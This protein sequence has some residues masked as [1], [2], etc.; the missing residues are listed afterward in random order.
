MGFTPPPCGS[1][2]GN[3]S[4]FQFRN[5]LLML[6]LLMIVGT[7]SA[8]A[9]WR[10]QGQEANN[11]DGSWGN[12][13]NMTQ[14]GSSD[15]WYYKVSNVSRTIEFKIN[16][17]SW[18]NE[19]QKYYEA[20]TDDQNRGNI[21]LVCGHDNDS[22]HRF[23]YEPST[24]FGSDIARDLYVFVKGNAGSP[25]QSDKVWAIAVRPGS[26]TINKQYSLR[27]DLWLDSGWAGT[28]DYNRNPVFVNMTNDVAAQVSYLIP[29]PSGD[30]AMKS[31]FT[32]V[33][34][35]SEKT[36]DHYE[37]ESSNL[38][39]NSADKKYRLTIPANG[40]SYPTVKRIVLD[41]YPTN[42][43]VRARL[44]DYIVKRTGWH[45]YVDDK[46]M[47]AMDNNGSFTF[48]NMASGEH[49]MYIA[50]YSHNSINSSTYDPYND[51]GGKV[52]AQQWFGGLFIDVNP[53]HSN[54]IFENKTTY[55]NSG[56]D[57]F[58]PQ[59]Y[60]IAGQTNARGRFTISGTKDV[61][62]TFD[63]GVI[64]INA[65][66][67]GAAPE[68][69]P[70]ITYTGNEFMFLSK[71]Q[72]HTD[73]N[74][75]NFT[76]DGAHIFVYFWNSETNANA[77]SDEAFM[78]DSGDNVLGA[79][80]PAGTWTNC[81]V[82][83]KNSNDSGKNWN[84]VWNESHDQTL[85]AGK[86]YLRTGETD[87][88]AVYTP[89]FYLTGS[90]VLCGADWGYTGNGTVN[91]GTVTRENIPAGTY[92][93]KLNPTKNYNGWEHQINYTHVA[94]TGSNVTL[95]SPSDN[96][97]QFTLSEASDVTIAYDGNGV[98]VNAT[99]SAP[100]PLSG[101]Y[102][103]FGAGGTNWVTNW[104]RNVEANKMTIVD[105]VATKTFYNVSGQGLEFKI[106]KGETEYNNSLLL[107]EVGENNSHLIKKVWKNGTN[108]DFSIS[109]INI[110]HKADV[111]V[112]FDGE[113]IWLTAVPHPETVAGSDWYI[114]GSGNVGTEHNLEWGKDTQKGRGNE[115]KM[116]VQDG[117]A[118][119]TYYNVP[120]NSISYKVFRGSDNYEI[121]D[122]YYDASASS[123]IICTDQ[124]GNDNINVSLNNQN[125]CIHWDGTKIWTTEADPLPPTPAIH[126]DGTEY[127]FWSTHA[128][129]AD[130]GTIV[131][132]QDRT[133][134]LRFKN[135]TTNAISKTQHAA[136]LV[137]GTEND[138]SPWGVLAAKVPAGDWHQVQVL[139][140]NAGDGWNGSS[141]ISNEWSW[142][143][144]EDG[145]NYLPQ[146]DWGGSR[147][148][149]YDLT[150]KASFFLSGTN[151]L[152]GASDWTWNGNGTKYVA[153]VTKTLNPATYKFK[154]TRDRTIYRSRGDYNSL[155]WVEE[156]NMDHFD[157]EHSN[158]TCT[159]PENKQIQFVLS[160][161]ADVTIAWENYD[162]ITVNQVPYYNVTFD[163]DGG[164]AMDAQELRSGENA[165]NPGTPSRGSG[166]TFN[167]WKLSGESS[168]YDFSTPVTSDIELVA[169]WTAPT[170]YTVT[171]DSN[172]GS[173][174][175]AQEVV[176]NETATEPAEP[177]RDNY[178]FGGWKLGNELYN[179]STP[180]TGNITLVADWSYTPAHISSV[181]I[182]ESSIYTWAG[183]A[184]TY[185]LIPTLV[186][187]DIASVTI[188]WSSSNNNVATV[189]NGVITPQGPGTA[190]I[191]CTATDYYDGSQTATCAV[192][193]APCAKELAGAPSYN[194]TITGYN[195]YEDGDATLTGMWN[196]NNE[197]GVMTQNTRLVRI[198]FRDLASEY[199][200]EDA[201]GKVA[202]RAGISD[203]SDKWMYYSAGTGL[204]YLQ[205]YKTGHYLYKDKSTGLMGQN[206]DWKFYGTKAA[207]YD[208]ADTYRWLEN[209]SGNELR[210]CNKDGYN[211]G[212]NGSHTLM[213]Y[214]VDAVENWNSPYIRCGLG[215]H[216]GNTP[217]KAII[218]EVS[219]SVANPFFVASQMN[220][221]YYR[222]KANATVQANLSSALA[223]ADVISVE[224]YADAATSVTLCKTNGDVVATIN[225]NADAAIEYTYLVTAGTMLDG[226]NAF[227]IKAADNHAGIRS[228][229]VTPMVTADPAQPDLHW[230]T[231]PVTAHLLL[232]GNFT[233]TAASNDSQ[234]AISY[235]S[236]DTN[237]AQVDASTGEVTPSGAGTTNI[238]ATIAADECHSAYSISYE[239]SFLGLQDYINTDGVN[240]VTLPGDYTSEN[241]VINKPFTINGA[242]HA[243]GNLTVEM[244]GDLTLSGALTVN[245]FS[246][247]AKAGNTTT[248]AASGQVRNATNLTANGNA[249]FYYTVDPSGTVH[250]GW[251]DFTV[252]F[253]VNVMT[254][255]A[256]IENEVL[257]EDFVNERNY[258]I[259]EHLGEK[260]AAGE[261]AYKKFRGVMEPCRLYSITLDDDYNY[262]TIRF[263]KA[264]GAIAAG[265]EVTLNAYAG[266]AKH[267]NWNGVGNGTL[268]HA[269]VE[270]STVGYIQVYQSGT[271][272]FLPV[273]RGQ[274]SLVV[275]S[276]FMI[277]QAGTMTLNQASHDKLLAPRRAASV[278]PTAIQIASE[279][280]PF[281]DQLF[282]SADETAGQGYTQGVD[283]AK[284]GNIGNVN[285]PQI[286]TNAYDSKLCA[287]EAQ[288]ING[289]AAYALSLYAPANGTY[290]LT[291]KNI[292]E[293]YTLYLTQ[294]G[295]KIWDMS[296]AYVI[297]LTKG[298]TNEYGLLLVERYNAPT[299]IE[300]GEWTNGEAQK[301]LRNGVLYIIRNGEVF[302][303]Q[304]AVMK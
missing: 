66:E 100:E 6:F 256:G 34:A 158:V 252:P 294:N 135:T 226:E 74:T 251:Y 22:K 2:Q 49:T 83:R 206:G 260:Q 243:I 290:T 299:G 172:G 95:S 39:N 269:D 110:T 209:G 38:T 147:W 107:E 232:D 230:T 120:N 58:G 20:N 132:V 16:N 194:V 175:D 117:V 153:S 82:V 229:A 162:K 61:I 166:Y 11:G 280:Q 69:T 98:T 277:Q 258:A 81:K 224:L 270:V 121:N 26:G 193:V 93:F 56:S 295:N 176:E 103:V 152:T 59:T 225:L 109:D 287:H 88:W 29:I 101:D 247:Y 90:S 204:F 87:V 217:I 73:G 33:S 75:F 48:E 94:S 136:F 128:P 84:N 76:A 155:Q 259:M 92:Q 281:S 199:M 255:I 139:R 119:I 42:G 174:V 12:G 181:S 296:D 238:T 115:H 157:S 156:G 191:T 169:D 227:I 40:G 97:I 160:R 9:G 185:T 279:G 171:F 195:S 14:V 123:G 129:T 13:D 64:T 36:A 31:R 25:S 27:G 146:R 126:Y 272:T 15:V 248:P 52:H 192:K 112:H 242:G 3:L 178:T 137:E 163:S 283:V 37:A 235:A 278:Q 8:W 184:I 267:A 41:Y 85:E 198:A 220:S 138:G 237:I 212:L 276:A 108:I 228:I 292:P 44:E 244:A 302:N 113:H 210:I 182:N 159:T 288:L 222:M 45:L 114:M 54:V 149:T 186:P 231:T 148:S 241:I 32:L 179:F 274:Y 207:S 142:F 164:S 188:S 43:Y 215:G 200:T 265:N 301:V 202:G 203:D 245:D 65:Y 131:A 51:N 53:A 208:D 57:Y 275:G 213:R 62:F 189:V 140:V 218:T 221:S 183:D 161:K 96:Q 133:M 91:N 86:N 150:N 154:L 284:A 151:N 298:T 60:P 18:E 205:N 10:F 46:Y 77:W 234:G 99:P 240:S 19:N 282:I 145:K 5:S 264:D 47:G 23:R 78:W 196:E 291:S 289:Q 118:T 21:P 261:Y 104:T 127:V 102:Y 216:Q 219:A 144:L 50:N 254:G 268:H 167:F 223:E 286:W 30:N 165:T 285:V 70:D 266:E 71:D 80:V 263:K 122:F 304:G 249:Y 134:W 201:D 173:E 180:V 106:H 257:N 67:H 141:D 111:T 55:Y 1:S 7:G 187:A 68:P 28:T 233:Y 273:D 262:N 63:G 17:G 250:F 297:D 236:E 170:L 300:N 79:K 303:A 35:G 239:V 168:A 214:Y 177:T 130:W 116:T 124:D 89:P 197:N 253:R 72:Q 143:D 190:T 4:S 246:I 293:G 211:G 125:I 105:G 24:I 271:K